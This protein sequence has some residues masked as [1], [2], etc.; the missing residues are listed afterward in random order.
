MDKVKQSVA[1]V[2]RKMGKINTVMAK[3]AAKM[4]MN[5]MIKQ[6]RKGNSIKSTIKK[7]IK[8]CDVSA[9]NQTWC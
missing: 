7:G 3:G 1:D 4:S 8:A 6:A 5:D 9:F 2:E